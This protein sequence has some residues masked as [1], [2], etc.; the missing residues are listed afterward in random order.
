MQNLASPKIHQQQTVVVG[1]R[2]ISEDE[3]RRPQHRA[4]DTVRFL[5]PKSRIVAAQFQKINV[6]AVK[7]AILFAL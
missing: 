1:F 3:T 6:Q 7:L 2:K 4:V 5:I